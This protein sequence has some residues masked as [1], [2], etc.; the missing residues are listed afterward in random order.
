MKF[1]LI[2]LLVLSL[3]ACVTTTDS[4]FTRK[5]DEDKAL[6]NY[7][8]LGLAYIQRSDFERARANINRALEINEDSSEAFAALA[9]LYQQ[10]DENKLAEEHF[11]K[12]LSLDGKN[13]RGR[14][15]YAAFLYRQER[16]T[17]ALEQFRVASKDTGYKGRAL[18]YINIAQCA[19]KLD[20]PQQAIK[21]YEKSLV[22]DRYQPQA[23]IGVT[24]LLIQDGEYLKAQR[25]YN[26]MINV[27]RSSGMTH[28]PTS[29][30]LGIEI[31]RH[32]NN[33]GQES[34]YALL[35]K[36]LYPESREYQQYRT[37]TAND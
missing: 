19:L 4:A 34:S 36:Q 29:L 22:L 23:L 13:T 35:L 20:D 10:E 9:L 18:I 27:I 25:Y 2:G 37:L 7:I 1:Y 28:S 30:W 15:F 32:F 33:D 17:E 11:N 31:A 21:A 3:T 12:A 8:Q 24:Q 6:D 26:R 5:A 14:T 16:Y